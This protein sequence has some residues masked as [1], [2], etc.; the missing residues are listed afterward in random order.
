MMGAAYRAKYG[1]LRDKCNFD[2]IIRSLPELTI[3]CQPYDDA[4]SVSIKKIDISQFFIV[5]IDDCY[6]VFLL[7]DAFRSTNL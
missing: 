4:E 7:I 2:E 3:A 6:I 1:L 5:A